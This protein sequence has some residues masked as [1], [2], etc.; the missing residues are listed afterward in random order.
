MEVVMAGP[1]EVLDT[2]MGP[3]D[4][5]ATTIRGYLKALLTAVWR[6]EE[7]F[8][9]KRPFGNSGWVY[10]V[11]QAMVK[12][13]HVPGKLDQDGYMEHMTRDAKE[14]ADNMIAAAIASLLPVEGA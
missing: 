7:G 10:D 4:S 6:K 9:G 12:A 8:S 1:Q 11:Y 13:G 14:Q 3:N 2:P 5:G